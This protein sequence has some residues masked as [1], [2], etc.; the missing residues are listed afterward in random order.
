[1]KKNKKLLP[2]SCGTGVCWW[3][4]ELRET[5]K[6]FLLLFLKKEDLSFRQFLKGARYE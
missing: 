5:D 1:L 6:S 2:V 3:S 4:A